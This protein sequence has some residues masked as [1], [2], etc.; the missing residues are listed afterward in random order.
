MKYDIT[1]TLDR[2]PEVAEELLEKFGDH[3]VWAFDAPMGAGKTTLIDEI[4]KLL[5]IQEEKHRDS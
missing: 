4:C 1:Y 3:R 5:R 2:L